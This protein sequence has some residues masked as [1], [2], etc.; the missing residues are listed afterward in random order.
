[1]KKVIWSVLLLLGLQVSAADAS[2][3]THWMEKT[4]VQ[5]Q[6][7]KYGE[8]PER[9]IFLNVHE[10]EYTSIQAAGEYLEGRNGYFIAVKQNG[11]RNL[12]FDING[13]RIQFDPNRMF[14]KTGRVANLRLLN[15]K[16]I[17]AAEETVEEFSDKI[18]S[19]VK[20][21]RLVV[22]LHNNTNGKPLS[23]NSY[24]T[25]YRN[26]AMD[27]DDFVLTTEK[28]IFEQMKA[29]K[30][31]A[32]LET[33]DSSP[34]DGSLAYFCSKK[35]IP[36]INVEA[37]AGHKSEQLRMLKALTPIINKYSN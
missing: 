24:R 19:R 15:R 5:L 18:I 12:S 36:Y 16:Y 20:N 23:V 10:N 11:T 29:R 33:T 35:G 3:E 4:P 14:T 1:M 31:N 26:P 28:S 17:P 6:L 34:D 9:V 7:V 13:T 22:A 2:T 25:K 32:V 8:R 37:Q 30:I 27:P 21:A